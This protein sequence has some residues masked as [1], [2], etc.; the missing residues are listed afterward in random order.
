METMKAIILKKSFHIATTAIFYTVIFLLL[1]FTVANINVNQNSDIANVFGSGFHSIESDVIPG[2][3]NQMLSTK[4]IALVKM[5]D[6]VLIDQLEIGDIITYYSQAEHQLVT[7]R[8]VEINLVDETLYFT[9]QAEDAITPDEPIEASSVIA[10]Y[11]S[12]I[13][14]LGTFLDYLQSPVGFAILII[15]PVLVLMVIESVQL[16]EGLVH[17]RKLKSEARVKKSY[18]RILKNLEYET[19]RIRHEVMSN[20]ITENDYERIVKLR[21]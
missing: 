13:T 6:E 20:W 1:L 18:R 21:I 16:Y 5:V 17:Y 8:I 3:Q 9:T 19:N 10:V 14:G 15:F 4:D 12:S 2:D 11:Q 7:H